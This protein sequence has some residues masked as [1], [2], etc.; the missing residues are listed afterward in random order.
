MTSASSAP[1]CR[2]CN[3]AHWGREPHVFP[4]VAKVVEVVQPVVV[5]RPIPV[6]VNTDKAVVNKSR[7]KDRHKKEARREYM[8]TYM[9]EQRASLK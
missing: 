2:T 3:H 7:S 1:V 4:D 5:N 9:R 8:R 6:V